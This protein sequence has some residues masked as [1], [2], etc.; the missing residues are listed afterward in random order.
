MNSHIKYGLLVGLIGCIATLSVSMMIGLAG[1]VLVLLAGMVAG[2]LTARAQP[3]APRRMR[4]IAGALAG[5]LSAIG[6]LV[7]MALGFWYIQAQGFELLSLP[8]ATSS[9]NIWII[10][11]G[12]TI[13]VLLAGFGLGAGGGALAAAPVAMQ[14]SDGKAGQQMRQP[15]WM[16]YGIMAGLV[17]GAAWGNAPVGLMIGILIGIV[18]DS[19]IAYKRRT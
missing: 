7:G 16:L 12:L 3:E 19:M 10:G 14:Y 5:T 13:G 4:T 2:M 17:I 11:I 9:A 8:S 1:L 18:I 15:E 6:Q